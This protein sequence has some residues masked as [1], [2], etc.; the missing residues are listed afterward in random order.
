MNSAI[1]DFLTTYSSGRFKN[2]KVQEVPDGA[3]LIL[4]DQVRATS[5]QITL[6]QKKISELLGHKLDVIRYADHFGNTLTTAI[7]SLVP[8]PTKIQVEGVSMELSTK[9]TVRL[10][11]LLA[12][13]QNDLTRNIQRH[14]ESIVKGLIKP[15]GISTVEIFVSGRSSSQLTESAVIKIIV[16]H[17]PLNIESISSLINESREKTEFVER[18]QVAIVVDRI[19]RKGLLLWQSSDMYVPTQHALSLFSSAT[20]RNSSDVKRALALARRKW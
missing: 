19:R 15:L 5:R 1:E 3:F 14:V 4:D 6:L 12:C 16:Q 8:E 9:S 13:N 7:I 20:S 17:A 11:I 18:A 10:S 2:S